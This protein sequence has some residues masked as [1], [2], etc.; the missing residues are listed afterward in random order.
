MVQ[1]RVQYVGYR[2][3]LAEAAREQGL[4]GWVKNNPDGTVEALV[5][6]PPQ[7]IDK[8]LEAV[9][10]PPPPAHVKRVDTQPTQPSPNLTYF[11]IV[12]G[13]VEEEL[14]EGFGSMQAIFTEYWREFRDFRRESQ[15]FHEEFKDFRREFQDFRREFQDF[16]QEFREFAQRTD[17]NFKQ[18]MDRYGEINKKLTEILETLTHESKETRERL[19]Q[20]LNLLQQA[21]DKLAKA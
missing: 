1:G 3:Y 6:G 2:R 9:K 21:V 19:T 14:Q 13:P 12:T 5:Q 17:D 15:G 7:A 16:R 18:V 11:K 20:A 10:N 4:A 8:F